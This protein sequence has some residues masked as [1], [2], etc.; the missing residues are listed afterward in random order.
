MMQN[1]LVL[2]V[3]HEKFGVAARNKRLVELAEEAVGKTSS[4]VYAE[5]LKRLEKNL[6]RC[7]HRS[8]VSIDSDDDDDPE[9]G[10]HVSAE[11]LATAFVDSTDLAGGIG[12]A[13]PSKIDVERF[14]HPKQRRRKDEAEDDGDTSTDEDDDMIDSNQNGTVSGAEED[15]DLINGDAGDRSEVKV[16]KEKQPPTISDHQAKL[17][18]IRDHLLLLAEHQY[19]FVDRI[20]SNHT[21]VEKWAVNFSALSRQL[22]LLELERTIFTRYGDEA[23][24]V[25]RILQEKGKLDE[26]AVT[27]IGLINQKVI[28]AILT[29]M[30]KSGHLEL[31]EIPRDNHRQPSRTMY[32]WFFDPERC[33]QK[34]L[35]ETYK[36]MARCMQRVKVEKE[37]VQVTIDKAARTDVVGKED[38][39]L[40]VDE[41][42]TLKGWREMEER[43]LGEL[44]RLDDLVAVLRDF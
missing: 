24:R 12:Y 22:R 29:T 34:V 20:H 25:I 27:N 7:H 39:Y 43:I 18:L 6:R 37:R 4:K 40:G 33:R 21:R 1:N 44:G 36:A 5:L 2:K 17:N 42:K 3:N 8:A 41:R 23:L 16:L 14:I 38:E 9:D 11:E 15:H 13:D 10:Q 31:Q 32:F 30:H 28:R 35:E 19:A 26:K